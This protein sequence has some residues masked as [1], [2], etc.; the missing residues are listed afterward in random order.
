MEAMKHT[1]APIASFMLLAG[2]AVA[3]A[4]AAPAAPPK[5]S[6]GAVKIGV[7]TD[8]SGIYSD[9]GGPGS[10]LAARMAVEDFGG[11]LGGQPVEVLA[12]DTLNKTDTAANR[13]RE[14]YDRDGVDL[15]VDLPASSVALAVVQV[16]KAKG[17]PVAVVG[18]AATRVTNEDCGS[19]VFHWAYDTYSLATAT[20]R[21]VLKQGGDSWF[22]LTADYAGGHALAKDA[23]DVVTASGGKVLGEVRHPFPG[24]DFSSYL[25]K[26]AASGAKVIGLANAGNDTVNTIKQAATFGIT[27][28]QMLAATLLFDTDVH[29][30][31]LANAQGMYLTT[32]FYWDY[33]EATRAFGRRFFAVHKRMPTMVQAGVYSAVLHYLKSVKAAGTDEPAAVAAQMKK[34]PVQDFFARGGR[35]REDG[36]MVHDMYLAQVKKPAESKYPWDYFAIR[37]VIKG[38]DAFQPLARSACPLVKH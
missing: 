37:Q 25:L 38:D 14:W 8:L 28:K 36:R 32:G 27:G 4:P 5:L 26:A 17:K 19:T 24:N 12:A 22:F 7:L 31:G 35:V 20:A 16:A 9:I 29:S 10:V 18:A 23:G 3:A 15:I 2:G 13:A 11:S 21:A 33:D 6:N 1:L 34:L 30:I